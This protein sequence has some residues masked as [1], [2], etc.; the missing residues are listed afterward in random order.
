MK[1][2]LIIVVLLWTLPV[3][4]QSSLT[5][6]LRLTVTDPSGLGVKS[7]VE[8]IS[9]ANQYHDTLTTDDQ[10][11]LDARR[12]PY[13]IYQVQIQAAGFA[14]TSE[15]VEIRSALPVDRT[16]RLK[17]AS[18]SQSVQVTASDTLVDP[19][20]AGSV[21]EMGSETIQNRLTALP[22]R[23]MQD[24]VNSEPGWL[25]E[26]NAVLH[27]RGSEY[28]T[29]FV[30]DG[31]PLT[32]NR[33]PSF[34]PEPAEADDVEALTIYTAGIP[35]EFGR[36][37]GGVVEVTT[38]K[39][40]DPGFHGQLTLFGGTY[41][42]AGI[43]TQD[44]YTWNKNT[45]GLSASGNMTGH[46]LNPVVPENYT[47]NGTT[48]NF[49]ASY[50]RELTPKDR[51]TFIVRHELA[52]YQIPNELVQQNGAYLPNAD[53]T[54]G[55]PPAPPEPSG[56][57]FIPGGQLQTG[58]NFETMGSVSYQHIFSP[59]AIGVLRGM[60]RDNSNDFYSNE[61]SWPLIATQHNDFKEIYFNGSV[62][63]HHGR[64]EWKAGIESD[65]IFLHENTKYVIPDC[66]DP[67]NPQCPINLGILDSGAITFAFQGQ[68]PDLEQS[69]Y[70]QDLIRLGNWTVNAGLRWDHYQ[71]LLNQNAVSPRLAVS[72]YFP[73]I[74]LNIHFS[75]DRI[76]QTPSFENILLA[77]SPA[78]EAIDTSVPALQ[79]PVQPSRGNYYELG[80]T[81]AFF[82]RLRLDAN[83]F[84]R[85]VNNYADDSQILSTGIS[86]PI[87]FDHA[88]LY[89]AEAKLQL[90]QW[91]G[92]SGFVSYSYI[93]GNA[94]FPVTGGLFLGDDAINPTT[95]HFPD[96]Q[97]QRNTVRARFRYQVVP[98][99]WVAWGCDYNTGL[100]F[101]PDLTPQQYAAE[102]GQVVV[103]HLNFNRDRISPY[104]T[105]NAS[106]GV[107][108]YQR[109]KRSVRFQADAQNLSN[110]L[111]L[112]DFGGLF[113]GNAIGPARQYSFRLVTS[114]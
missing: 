81:K 99:L 70:V 52:R 3:L 112:I 90:V 40:E 69:A 33:S 37:M 9:E 24:L 87:A 54:T 96:S 97:D 26:G 6:E 35:A 92:F 28:Q 108:L 11:H 102:Y 89:G 72:R 10:G 74:G 41:D 98:R 84:R 20:S 55:C 57:V 29:Q 71:L 78:A 64:Q 31:I 62:S 27:P 110:T 32:D 25:Y 30:V 17:V 103:N 1:K 36:K 73:T 7:T 50:E 34:G 65:A 56:C 5:G 2:A 23:S 39:N 104:F 86:F 58:D 16:I 93:V 114:F 21:N 107:D 44:Q 14:Q 82:G 91:K 49:S 75:Y 59:D 94:W 66:A 113:S 109:E 4:A 19:Y 85:Q 22:G 61:A 38:L 43:N 88:I 48:A 51:L 77:S 47:N 67:S 111:E 63:I 45:F 100:P 60:A 76:F 18:V 80:A 68:R 101:Q 12:L 13:G 42:T 106:V 83:M 8:L 15:T 95:G 46:Y 53:N 79:L 105:Q